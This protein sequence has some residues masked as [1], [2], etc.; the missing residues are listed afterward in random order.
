[1]VPEGPKDYRLTINGVDL[2]ITRDGH[3][4]ISNAKEIIFDAENISLLAKEE[5]Y[6]GT[7]QEIRMQSKKIHLNQD[8]EVGGYD[9]V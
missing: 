3:V 7:G 9:G 1:M 5:L 4:I 6:I 2:T 8:G